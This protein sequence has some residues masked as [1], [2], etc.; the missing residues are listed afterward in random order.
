MLLTRIKKPYGIDTFRLIQI[1][2]RNKIPYNKFYFFGL[3]DKYSISNQYLIL[4]TK[5]CDKV[6]DLLTKYDVSY[7]KIGY[8]SRDYV[9][10]DLIIGNKFKIII[11]GSLERIF[12]KKFFELYSPIEFPNFYGYQRFGVNRTNHIIGK[13]ILKRSLN[14]IKTFLT[15]AF[16]DRVEDFSSND[17]VSFEKI[18]NAI[19][20][21]LI[22]L[23][24]N[25]YQSYSFNRV[26]SHRIM[27]NYPLNKCVLGDYC[28]LNTSLRNIFVCREKICGGRP[29]IPIMGYGYI[30]KNRLSDKYYTELLKEEDIKPRDFYLGFKGLKFFGG[31]RFASLNLKNLYI[32]MKEDKENVSINFF[33]NRGMYATIFLR[34]LIKP[35]H[36]SKHGF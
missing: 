9:S 16:T 25:A 28:I 17:S 23:Y 18:L 31:F 15:D 14:V 32:V 27:D 36:P 19:P 3:K 20:K 35:Q 21:P 12:L 1:L 13:A 24:I 11:W 22:K 26:L 8:I 30:L 7:S 4:H 5:V 10:K 34:E 29:I 2:L 6:L 33:M